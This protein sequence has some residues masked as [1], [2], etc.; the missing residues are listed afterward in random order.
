MVDGAVPLGVEPAVQAS[1]RAKGQ[2]LCN[3]FVE[4]LPVS[5]ASISVVGGY[6]Q[7]TV[8]TSD[9]V[10]ARVEEL[11]FELGEGPHHEA[12]S[13]GEPVLVPEFTVSQIARWP[14][15]SPAL[16]M[17]GVGALFAFPLTIGA[18][19][20][21]VVDMYRS[22]P[23]ELDSRSILTALTLASWTAGPALRL[24]AQ[25][26][27]SEKPG[28]ERLVPEIRRVVH[29]ATGMILV[30]LGVSAT[31]AFSRLQAH[32]FSSGETLEY[33]A[34]EVVARRIDFRGMAD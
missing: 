31:E 2:G 10:A 7:L 33:V 8:G 27:N 3:R 22:S 30:Q 28:A 23:G 14:L 15:L 26:A 12:L 6:G 9:P 18:A 32:A 20:V 5:G 17:I 29:Q 34:N 13:S 19:T 25:S 21:G 4:S 11:Q 1:A 16:A 24:A